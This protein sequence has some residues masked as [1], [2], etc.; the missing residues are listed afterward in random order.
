[1]DTRSIAVI[2]LKV[3]GLVLVSLGV[4]RLVGFFPI[5]QGGSFSYPEILVAAA[6]GIGPQVLLGAAFWFFPGSIA[7]R[8]VS[9]GTSE[10]S[11]VQ[12]REFQ[13]IAITV[14]GLYLV[15]NALA[16]AVYL[17]TAT[18]SYYRQ[19]P[20]MTFGPILGRVAACAAELAIGAAFCIGTKGIVRI[21]ERMRG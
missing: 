16:D 10:D 19:S 5:G 7:N 12:L 17:A 8:I 4:T 3:A 21:I 13:L 18:I 6:L 11:S 2:L 1:M 15:A 20:D 9:G 14:L